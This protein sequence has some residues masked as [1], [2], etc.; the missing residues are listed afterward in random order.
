MLFS[1]Y[2][3]MFQNKHGTSIFWSETVWPELGNV[4]SMLVFEGKIIQ[5]PHLANMKVCVGVCVC[6]HSLN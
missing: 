2:S 1:S 3:C 6:V 5:S 4:F